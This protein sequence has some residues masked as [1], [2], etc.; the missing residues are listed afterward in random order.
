VKIGLERFWKKVAVA[1]CEDSWNLHEGT[2]E[3]HQNS[4]SGWAVCKLGFEPVNF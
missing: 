4:Q 1:K 2:K 3:S